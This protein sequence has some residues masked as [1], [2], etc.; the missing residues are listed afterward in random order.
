MM[1]SSINKKIVAN[2]VT[3]MVILAGI[4]VLVMGMAMKELTE[5]ILNNVLPSTIKAA[6]QSVEGNIHLLADRIFMI[7]EKEFIMRRDSTQDEKKE[8]LDRVQS[9][10]EFL[11]LGLYD[12]DG[13]LYLGEEGCPE[14]IAG[15]EMFPLL[16]E[17]QNLVIDDVAP[18]GEDLE[19]AV[20]LPVMEDGELLYYLVGSYKYDVLNDV[21]S[22]INLSANSQAYLV[23][24]EGKIMGSR[25]T[26][27]IR[28]DANIQDAVQI[29][30][31]TDM[32]VSGETRISELK[33][34]GR[35]VYAGYTPV[36]GT[37][38]HL[39]VIVPL[40]DFMGPANATIL[41]SIALTAVLLIFA[42]YFTL[43]FSSKIQ[44]SLKGVTERIGL[45]AQ[46][47]LKTPTE[48]IRTNDETELL[49][50]ALSNTVDSINGYISELSHI[51]ERMAK[52]DFKVE[53]KGTF[54]G[55]FVVMKESLN[56]IIDALNKM[57]IG[58]KR[59]SE[60]VFLTAN[61]VSE[62][63]K[64]VYN[65][66]TEQSS[67]LNV[68]SDETT[69]IG[70]NVHEVD[71]NARLV[72]EMVDTVQENMDAGGKN[73]KNL[74]QAMEDINRNSIEITKINK[75]LEDISF[76]TN[77]LSLNASIE[78]AR[79]G[80]AGGGFAVVADEV[81]NLAAQSAESSKRTSEM[82]SDIVQAIEQG[83][84]YAQKVAKSFGDI[85]KVSGS[86][87]QITKKLEKSVS[88]Q[89]QSLEKITGQITQIR[90]FAQQNL[91]A[92]FES[93]TASEKLNGQAQKLQEVSG[94]F[95]L[96]EGS[97]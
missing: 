47:D 70:Q 51:L 3:I 87:S 37:R 96:R 7:G 40:G 74:L 75:F 19:L 82:I 72:G 50:H 88:I 18:N 13:S 68:L 78:A 11:W 10:I 22:N 80:E 46:G 61:T 26:Q 4:L 95:Q 1:K 93:T 86:I 43:K 45:L 38:W 42:I 69:A 63:A 20:G 55:D 8:V 35:L 15:R 89:K 17:T 92:S 54:D 21:M 16:K 12:A 33:Q 5:R 32:V 64:L 36:N 94:S 81:R 49:S 6:S 85:G 56:H 23:N 30:G 24:Y 29:D 52:G 59:L 66:S 84:D 39:A 83:T 60:D 97:L 77:I 44:R 79:A 27:L 58:I 9:E 76:Q 67:S 62:S 48:V 53:V 34:S 73:M 91:N 90:D 2:T 25:N 41:F 28:E 65:D 57:L 71:E 14:S 31:L